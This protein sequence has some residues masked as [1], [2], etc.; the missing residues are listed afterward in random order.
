MTTVADLLDRAES[1]LLG[2]DRDELNRLA[3]A[4]DADDTELTVDFDAAGISEGSYLGIDL[5]VLYV[6]EVNEASS[7][8]TVQRGMLGSTAAAHDQGAIV[9]VNPLFSRWE[10]LQGLNAELDDLSAS[11]LYGVGSFT[12]T[13]QSPTRT[14]EID[15]LLVTAGILDILEVRWDREGSE[16]EW[17]LISPRDYKLIRGLDPTGDFASG[18]ALRIDVP[19]TTGRTI[20]VRFAF[21]FAHATGLTQDVEDDLFLPA[22]A[23]DIPPLGIAARIMGTREAKRAFIERTDQGR[24]EVTG[25]SSARASAVLMNLRNQR[26]QSELARLRRAYPHRN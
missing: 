17:P 2:G 15:S 22:T 20:D 24:R 3:A 18:V 19:L 14:Y 13:S 11:G 12:L 9:Y 5:E 1:H 7:T 6:W 8:V 10:L 23:H 26:I 16:N 25:G 21:P 4:M